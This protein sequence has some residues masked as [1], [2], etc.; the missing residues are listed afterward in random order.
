MLFGR[1]GTLGRLGLGAYTLS[2]GGGAPWYDPAAIFDADYSGVRFRWDSQTFTDEATFNTAIGATKASVQRTI[3]PYVGANPELI[4]NGG[5]ATDFTGWTSVLNGTSSIAIVAA[6]ARFTSDGTTGVGGGGAGIT[7]GVTTV[8]DRAYLATYD[9]LLGSTNLRIGATTS[10]AAGPA[11]GTKTAA[12]GYKDTFSA[13]GTTSYFYAFRSGAGTTGLDNASV[14]ECVPFKNFVQGGAA[15]RIRGTTP[16]AASGTK[17]AVS[18]D[19][20]GAAASGDRLDLLYDATGHLRVQVT[21]AGTLV[22]NLDLGVVAVSTAFDVVLSARANRFNAVLVGV[23][24]PQVDT[25]GGFPGV[26]AMYI[27][28]N[29]A[30]NNWDGSELRVQVYASGTDEAFYGLVPNAIHAE[31]DSFIGGASGVVLPTTLQTGMARTVYNTG[32]GGS[33]MTDIRDR[34]I[35]ASASVKS[36]VTLFWDGSENGITT[37]S[38]YCDLL[39]QAITALGHQRFV[40]IPAC[41]NSGEADMT[42]V[43]Q[44]AAEMELRWPN[45]FLDWRDYLTLI[46][47]GSYPADAMFVALPGDTTHLSQAA[48]DLMAAAI[49]TFIDGKGW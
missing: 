45:N 15:L 40:V 16:T 3:G 6:T 20:V 49:E 7:Q 8:I 10:T 33:T 5:F 22:A 42:L 17:V 39:G 35:A 23:G 25:G 34:I 12:N 46:A 37:V 43:N 38:D 32:I 2:K 47:P 36:K 26:G 44:I 4:T 9:V 29:L 21:Y 13:D 41:A 30:G 11:G 18:L 48:M 31:G 27:G 24:V 19:Q 28:K 14:K 1:L